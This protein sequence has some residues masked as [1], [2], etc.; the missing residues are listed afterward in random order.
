LEEQE[1]EGLFDYSIVIVD[2]D[3]VESARQIVEEFARQATISIS[4]YVEPVQNIALARNKAVEN[5]N[6]D[7]IS[8]IDDDEYPSTAW[9]LKLYTAFNTYKPNGGVMGP[10]VP[11]Y[12][13]GTPQWL[14]KS[15][16]CDRPNHPTGTILN[17]N[18][19]RTGNAFLSTRIFR[20]KGFLFDAKKGRTG[21]EDKELFKLLMEHGYSFI[22]CREA[23]VYEVIYPARWKL[24]HYLYRSLMNGGVTGK[25]YGKYPAYLI[26]S[27]VSLFCY[28][29][30]LSVSIFNGKHYIY[31]FFIRVVYDFGRVMGCLAI[32]LE[33]ERRD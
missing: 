32:V 23:D 18:M 17:W 12:P 22:W 6:G 21:G 28:T 16:I 27:L 19:T 3:R 13:D 11:H 8:F 7:F 31:K 26:R 15:K 2:N 20:E 5:A 24:S 9:L 30:L 4:Y 10:V 14:I 33:K 29:L 25:E 1:T